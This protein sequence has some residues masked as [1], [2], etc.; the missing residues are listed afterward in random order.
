MHQAE[1]KMMARARKSL[2]WP[3]ITNDVA[4]MALTCRPCQEYKPSNR[5]EPLRAHE[6][7]TYPFQ[8]V[9]MDLGEVNGK[10][11]LIAV[12]QFSSFPQIYECGKTAKTSQVISFTINLFENFSV[13][14][15]IYSD[16]GPQFKENGEFDKFCQ[17]WGIEHVT[18]SPYMSRSNGVAEEAVKEMKKIIR[19]N[20]SP[21]GVLN[22]PSTVAGL[23]MFRNTP[24][25]PTDL[26]PAQLIFGQ[27]IRDSLPITRASLTPEHRFA[28]EERLHTVRKEKTN[29]KKEMELLQQ[30]QK[31]FVQNPSSKRWTSTATIVKFGANN[32]EYIIRNDDTGKEYR[33]NR[34]F[35]KPQ[36]V[37]PVTPPR[38]P[39]PAPELRPLTEVKQ[40]P[41]EPSVPRVIPA[42]PE[43]AINNRPQRQKKPIVRFQAGHNK[44]YEPAQIIED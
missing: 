37:T 7:A 27:D 17:D 9:H 31:V 34:R 22:R 13:P 25:S 42:G 43:M 16:G 15:T 26:S 29:G 19:A 38:Q 44:Y 12:D 20:I 40:V 33:R 32:R 6:K 3:F 39:V 5:A 41:S 28:V 2:W 10:Y 8:F 36:R 35:L 23:M 18:S 24:R 1:A 21:L 4:N 14:M 30:G 11:F